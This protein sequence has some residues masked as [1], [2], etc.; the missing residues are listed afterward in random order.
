MDKSFTSPK[1]T[2]DADAPLVCPPT[3]RGRKPSITFDGEKIIMPLFLPSNCSIIG[4]NEF[5]PIKMN[6]N[7]KIRDMPQADFTL[8]NRQSRSP[9]ELDAREIL[10]KDFPALPF[11]FPNPTNLAAQP[12]SMTLPRRSSSSGPKLELESCRSS[13]KRYQASTH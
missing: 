7:P 10:L 3:P 5:K 1:A 11:S 2:T 13:M 9:R 8:K 4:T 12:A 6:D